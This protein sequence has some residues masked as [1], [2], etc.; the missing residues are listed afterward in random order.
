MR[1][2]QWSA[3]HS[4]DGR[5]RGESV[6]R[7]RRLKGTLLETVSAFCSM[8]TKCCL[9]MRNGRMIWYDEKRARSWK[10]SVCSGSGV[11]EQWSKSRCLAHSGGH[12][13]SNVVSVLRQ[14][15]S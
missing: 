14:L 8:A 5:D 3:L 11:K 10:D 13:F 1:V 2:R 4:T 6:M 7:I 12:G 15:R 9:S